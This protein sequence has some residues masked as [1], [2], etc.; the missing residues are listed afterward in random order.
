M[1]DRS[2]THTIKGY[3]YQFDYTILQI[4]NQENIENILTLEEI[5]DLD[6]EMA[7]ETTAV[8]CKYYE[9][10]DYSHSIIAKPI[11]LMLEDFIERKRNSSEEVSYK[12]YGYYKSGQDKLIQPIN[13]DF[14][15]STFLTYQKNK[16]EYKHHEALQATDNELEQFISTLDIDIN[17]S[18]YIHQLEMILEK[19]IEIFECDSF[20]AEHYYYNNALNEIKRLSIESKA[21]NRKVTKSDFLD[22]INKKQIIFNKWFLKIKGKEKYLRSL[23][24]KF[25]SSL[26]VECLDRFFLIEINIE[27]YNRADLIDL[28]LVISNKYSKITRRTPEKF[29]PFVFVSE[30]DEKEIIEIKKYLISKGR[31]FIDG[32]DFQGSE[33]STDSMLKPIS[34]ENPIH[35]KF[36]NNIN[37][38]EDMLQASN[39]IIH[40]Y[41]FYLQQPFFHHK[42]D[43]MKHI[44]IELKGIN[45]IKEVI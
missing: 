45:D 34:F 18:E 4:L 22:K 8:Q 14:L 6:I 41:Q 2:A 31:F 13:L 38:L 21:D 25:F 30:L 24:S 39:K 19:L 20:E 37:D 5:E 26:N 7:D 40:I 3:F 9:K 10:T 11:R 36:L 42:N 12:T 29:C 32:Y 16:V 1:S 15:K 28:L 17:A 35:I 44:K 43:N 27:E 33:F 23:R